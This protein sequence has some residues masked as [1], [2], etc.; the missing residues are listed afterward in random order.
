MSDETYNGWTNYETWLAK[1]WMDNDEGSYRF[2]QEQADWAIGNAP[3]NEFAG[4]RE[5]EV[6]IYLAEML[7]DHHAEMADEMLPEASVYTDLMRAALGSVNWHEIA[8]VLIEEAQEPRL[9]GL[10]I[11]GR[12]KPVEDL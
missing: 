1:L 7:K 10:E 8:N 5:Q 11:R 4:G 2:W 6:R 3:T 12:A 9:V